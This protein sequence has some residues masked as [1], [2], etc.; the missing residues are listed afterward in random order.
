MNQWLETPPDPELVPFYPSWVTNGEHV[1]LASWRNGEWKIGRGLTFDPAEI[2]H[3][4]LLKA[5]APPVLIQ[6]KSESNEVIYA[7]L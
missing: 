6:K 3:F 5:P 1:F 7:N 2:T 4:Q